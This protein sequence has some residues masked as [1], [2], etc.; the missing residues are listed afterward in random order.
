MLTFDLGRLARRIDCLPALE[1][2]RGKDLSRVHWQFLRAI[3]SEVPVKR[4][5]ILAVVNPVIAGMDRLAEGKDWPEAAATAA[6]AAYRAAG[7]EYRAAGAEYRAA[8]AAYHAAW[9]EEAAAWA[10]AWAAWAEEAA[11]W[12]ASS[13]CTAVERPCRK[14]AASAGWAAAA[15]AVG[16]AAAAE[17]AAKAGLPYARQREILVRL[18]EE[19]TE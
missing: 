9:A 12:V 10:A 1:A 3:L 5:N 13:S 11:I 2:A 6:G 8:G 16:V 17:A 14:S 19:A 18:I 7:A 15:A 4:A